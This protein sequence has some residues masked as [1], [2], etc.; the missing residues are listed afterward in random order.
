MTCT[1]C[2]G[3]TW[4]CEN[5]ADKSWPVECECGAGMPCGACNLE[6]ASAGFV[7]C[8]IRPLTAALKQIANYK[9]DMLNGHERF[10]AV[11]GI[12]IASIQGN[13]A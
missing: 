12:A 13:A 11:Q 9:N 4:V 5:H 3:E 10:E 1:N 6:M 8:A 2:L 7:D